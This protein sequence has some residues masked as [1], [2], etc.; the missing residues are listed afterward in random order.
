MLKST[1]YSDKTREQRRET[2][3][4][5]E[6]ESWQ[7][8]E[9]LVTSP[10]SNSY[11]E[12]S[13]MHLNSSS[14]SLMSSRD[15]ASAH[16]Y[17]TSF[18]SVD[19]PLSG[20]DLGKAQCKRNDGYLEKTSAVRKRL[21]F[22]GLFFTIF[23]SG[24]DQTVTSTILTRIADDFRALDRIEW[25][26]TVFMLCSTSLNVISGRIAD[27]F[28]RF[29][30]LMFSLV[31][32]VA[33]AVISAS[34]QS[35]VMFIFA[36]GLSGIACGGMLNLSI[37]I[38]SDIVPIERRGKY[39]G[40]LQICFGVSNAA[41]PLVGGLFADRF[42][43]RAAFFA[44]MAMGI[45][46]AVY[47]AI[48]LRLPRLTSTAT[49]RDGVRKLDYI[50]I[51][52]IVACISFIIVGLNIG[53][54]IMQWSS[55]ATI[56]CL[57]SGCV[58]LGAFVLIELRFARTPLIPMWLF[59]VRN[60]VIAFS[61]TFLCG[62]TMF[63]IIF[64]MPVY[65]SAVFGANAM[66]AGL[67]VLPFG[68]ALSGSSFISGYFM[69]TA[70]IYRRFLQLGPAFMAAGVLAIALLSGKTSEAVYAALLLIPGIGMGNVIVSNVIAAQASTDPQYISTVTPLCEFFLSI[71]GVIGVAL[72]GA[73]YRNKLSNILT[74][75][76]SDETQAVQRIIEEARKD[77]SVVYSAHV[78]DPLRTKI[79]EAYAESM[80][81]ALW[82]MLPFLCLALV[83][84][85]ALVRNPKPAKPK[86]AS[87]EP[88]EEL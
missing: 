4:V 47:L 5:V 21:M 54:T 43:W 55:P 41:G 81:E 1:Q 40:F 77:V 58:L 15:R 16:I 57:V 20:K 48:V 2:F 52:L 12:N 84:S 59:T 73:V 32:F 75:A 22:I 18:A 74:I 26:P 34:A 87:L 83:L 8:P 11:Q 71:G 33:G 46:T 65:F 56:G 42:D 85:L 60:L 72:F 36:R 45:T 82:V 17:S 86:E 53:G 64:Y 61:V 63:A 27:I 79:S 62:M 24:L 78:S 51:S 38:I 13:G 67:L 14:E 7:S 76:A 3:E 19:M 35:I 10:L 28:G 68:M 6:L 70:G 69:S 50:G 66:R 49:W 88:T 30:V 31:T 25:V 39:L 23:L 80:R 9:T 37:I 29:S 44:D